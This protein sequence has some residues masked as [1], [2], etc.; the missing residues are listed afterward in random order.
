M[1]HCM[2]TALRG[3]AAIEL[4]GDDENPAELVQKA[5]DDLTKSVDDR[6]KKVEEKTDL[7]AVTDRMDGLEA[8]INRGLGSAAANP[9]EAKA[10]EAKALNAFLRNGAGALEDADRKTLNLGSGAT[11]GYVT[12]PMYS[13]TIIEKITEISPMRSAAAVM[14]IGTE[15]VYL[16]VNTTK[17]AGGW[18][19]E[20][21]ARPSSEPAFDQIEIPVYEHAVIV[22][23][24]NQLLEDSFIDLQGYIA[25][26]IGTQFGKA[27]ATAF[28]TGDGAGKP[29][30]FLN[31]PTDFTSVVALQDGSDIIESLI[32]V[33]FALPTEYA[34]RA[35]WMMNRGTMALIRN[36]LDSSTKGTLWSDSLA[37]GT[38]PT[39]LG[40]PIAEAVDMPDFAP[41]TPADTYPIAFGDF[42]TGYQ[43]VDRIGVQLM[44]D[45]YTG[46]DN[47]IVKIR[48]R[49]R[50]GGKVVQP[51]A[52]ALM[53]SDAA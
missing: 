18:V 42:G 14:S 8:K 53:M 25:G 45:D 16:P 3:S 23:V 39:L 29:T 48:A 36:A 12:A 34:S 20:T 52:I 35:V 30:G 33:Y 27:E 17:L 44:R 22:P 24:S 51:E 49:R 6:L 28:V 11:G 10:I 37:N 46:A 21:G 40:R 31:S 15:K 19:T 38:P 7:K 50:V 5:L 41:E 26:Q 1:H 47:G 4:K 43:I 32:K 2:K 13:T 9:D